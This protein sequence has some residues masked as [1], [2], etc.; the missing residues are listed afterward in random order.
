MELGESVGQG[1]EED[2]RVCQ[3]L[4]Y[5]NIERLSR[6]KIKES[7]SETKKEWQ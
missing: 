4:E 3:H 6:K 1:R 5:S 2:E 7:T